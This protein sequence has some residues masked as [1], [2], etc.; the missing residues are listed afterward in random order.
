MK[1]INLLGIYGAGNDAL[2]GGALRGLIEAVKQDALQKG[3]SK[4][5]YVP[6]IMDWEEQITV[7]RLVKQWKDDTVILCHS[8]GCFT[9]TQASIED[10]M[11]YVPY[12]AAIA[13]SMF[14]SPRPVA[15]NVGVLEQFTSNYADFFNF[16]GR[17][18]ISKSSINNKTQLKVTWTGK[19]HLSAPSAPVV[20]TN[21]IAAVRAAVG[22]A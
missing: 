1:T 20:H 8:C 3:Y 22:V 5:L 7:Y 10:S 12:I 18:L 4:N 9:G 14:C 2:F 11:S 17:T 19:P 21:V 6:R 16:G 13:P 15:P